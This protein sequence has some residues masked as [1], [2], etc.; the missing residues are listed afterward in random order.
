MKKKAEVGE[1]VDIALEYYAHHYVMGT[2]PFSCN[3]H[4]KYEYSYNKVSVCLKDQE[5]SDFYFD[6][7]I[8]NQMTDLLCICDDLHAYHNHAFVHYPITS[9][10]CFNTFSPFI[11]P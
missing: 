2:Q 9:I 8:V 5:I 3:P 10:A 1:Y 6:L 7:K 11:M 4:E